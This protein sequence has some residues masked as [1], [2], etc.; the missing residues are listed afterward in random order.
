MAKIEQ[1]TFKLELT[2][3]EMKALNL[4]FRELADLQG[5]VPDNRNGFD[6]ESQGI[7]RTIGDQVA[8][9]LEEE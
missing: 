5:K 1:S 2:R 4:A 7:A 9:A 8:K 6:L 3:R